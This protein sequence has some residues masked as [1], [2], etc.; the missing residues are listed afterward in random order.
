MRLKRLEK[1][2]DRKMKKHIIAWI[3]SLF[4]VV[5]I[6]G[7]AFSAWKF[8]VTKEQRDLTVQVDDIP[9]NYY[10]SGVSNKSFIKEY[11]IYFFPSTLYLQYYKDYLDAEIK[12]PGQ[13]LAPEERY[14]YITPELDEAGELLLENGKVDYLIEKGDV[15]NGDDAY[16]TDL[17]TSYSG[18]D[19]Y[20]TASSSTGNDYYDKYASSALW[21]DK[22]YYYGDPELDE[23]FEGSNDNHTDGRNVHRYDRFGFWPILA[24][25]EGRYLPL[26][27]TVGTN[28]SIEFYSNAA[29]SP[30]ADM[31]DSNNWYVFYFSLWAYADVERSSEGNV[32]SYTL[33]YYADSNGF[34]KKTQDS[35]N[36]TFKRYGNIPLSA[37]APTKVDRYFDVV[38]DLEDYADSDGVIR[39][40]PKFSNGKVYGA[41][42]IDD[43][44]GDALRMDVTYND[45]LSF[46]GTTANNS[47]LS[48]KQFLISYTSEG[49]TFVSDGGYR[50]ANTKVSVL[51]NVN[52]DNYSQLNFKVAISSGIA[53]WGGDWNSVYTVKSDDLESLHKN[54]GDG[55]YNIYLFIGFVASAGNSDENYNF[56]NLLDYVMKGSDAN[57]QTPLFSSL[58]GKFLIDM[59]SRTGLGPTRFR[60]KPFMLA[61]EKI[62]DLRIVTDIEVKETTGGTE[63]SYTTD[64]T[65]IQTTYGSMNESFQ[66]MGAALYAL[67]GNGDVTGGNLQDSYPYC[68][69]LRNVDFIDAENLWFQFRFKKS[70]MEELAVNK[71][72]GEDDTIVFNPS[73]VTAGTKFEENQIFTDLTAYFDIYDGEEKYP[74][75]SSSGE[76]Q[77]FYRLKGET[78]EERNEMKGVYDF[79]V[80]YQPAITGV[81][82]T[83]LKIYVHRQANVF[84]KVLAN[85]PSGDMV[86]S[87]THFV[88]HDV[89]NYGLNFGEAN[90]LIFQKAYFLGASMKPEDKNEATGSAY[91]DGWWSSYDFSENSAVDKTL[92]ECIG[93][94]AEAYARTYNKT[95]RDVVLRDRVTNAIVAYYAEGTDGYALKFI[96]FKIRKNYVVY[97]T[98]I[99]G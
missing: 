94:Y 26:K 52:I 97:V 80:M 57:N 79:I 81:Q 18:D 78:D 30:M 74:K 87:E 39:L 31:G 62:Q 45:H 77:I 98:F 25:D 61:F 99:Q 86:D 43:G 68:Y 24:K 88:N 17:K 93:A 40:F 47:L 37:F 51:P 27:I 50:I 55:L 91:G 66:R 16:L 6:V 32:T 83:K 73:S 8:N 64:E 14:G 42:S 11:T 59:S 76:E 33:P 49:G 69:I 70:Y 90:A 96:H 58:K 2:E 75:V 38:S 65:A 22:N 3:A 89:A 29:M 60:N 63:E 15:Q 84:I 72:A 35:S 53:G 95:L 7:T 48:Q 71:G 44:G 34:L 20:L 19:Y 5:S 28:L 23:T 1:R 56:E 82:D 4:A 85:N 13:N 54:F 21:S 10:H 12:N 41:P 9:E 46:N 92:E 67:D 36:S